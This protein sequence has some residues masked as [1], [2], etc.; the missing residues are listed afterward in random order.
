TEGAHRF[1]ADAASLLRAAGFGV[2]LPRWV[3]ASRLGVRLTTRNT[4]PTDPVGATK[5][6]GFGLDDLVRFRAELAIGDATISA[7]ELA[8]L[9]KLKVPLVRVRGQW[10]ELDERQLAAALEFL[11]GPLSGTMTGR[12]VLAEVMQGGD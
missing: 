8:E 11:A 12:E 3:G 6:G 5:T 2:Q 10:V 7:D 9:A 1:L 4:T